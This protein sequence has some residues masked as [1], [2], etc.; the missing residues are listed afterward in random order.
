MAGIGQSRLGLGWDVAIFQEG[1]HAHSMLWNRVDIDSPPQSETLPPPTPEQAAQF[2]ITWDLSVHG[3]KGLVHG[4]YPP[5]IYNQTKNFIDSMNQ[6]G[7]PTS[8]D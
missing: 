7:V 3:T 5:F 1:M 6:L 8:H 4:S 2:G